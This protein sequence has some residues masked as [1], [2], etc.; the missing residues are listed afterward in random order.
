MDKLDQPD[1]PDLACSIIDQAKKMRAT[2]AEATINVDSGFAINVRKNNVDTIE[3]S[4]S[5]NLVVT[6]YF[7]NRTGSATTSDL[8]PAAISTLLEKARHIARFTE[9]DPFTGLAE[10]ELLADDYPDLDLSHPW[11]IKTDEAIALAK[12]CEAQAMG[13][14]KKIVNSEGVA[15]DSS[16]TFNVYA[17]SHGFCGTVTSTKHSVSCSL[18]SQHHDEMQRD[19]YYTIA[20]DAK[21]LEPWEEVA[22]K[23][24][25]K[26]V[27]RLGA[28][29][30]S[31]QECPVIFIAATAS[32]LIN[33]FVNAIYGFNLYQ[34][35]S[36][37]V[38][39]LHQQIFAD[40]LNIEENP[41]IPKALGSAPFDLEG[42]K[43]K[44]SDVITNG[45]LQRY[46]LDSYSARKLNLRTTGNAS[47]VHNLMVKTNGPDLDL[48]GLLQ[49]MGGGLLI[50][51][52]M[53]SGVNI[54]TGD[55]S[56]GAFGYWV[57]NG[58]IQYPVTGAT[59]AG[60]LKDIFLDIDTIANDIDHRHNI[61]T[62]SILLKKMMV[63][64]S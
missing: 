1:L 25:K 64:G 30:I 21:N 45:I 52:L 5:K 60:N 58:E 32:S 20:R 27:S 38:D 42:V 57:E 48:N 51:E 2:A 41:Y 14:D 9:E 4:K 3:H 23:A 13:Y 15:V 47:G 55:Y 40:Q 24:A 62:G 18:I 34:K 63:A 12:N 31:T 53:G 29:K 39:Q 10:K 56:R 16:A 61:L 8:K 26:T 35:N 54:V 44:R 7:G 37:L 28:K 19:Y 46:L 33:N 22:T 59:I 17:N 36:F 50:T 43:L 11:S 49:K 6:L